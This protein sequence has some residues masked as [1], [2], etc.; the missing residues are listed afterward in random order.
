M[1]RK[2]SIHINGNLKTY[3]NLYYW[4]SVG[5]GTLPL[6]HLITQNIPRMWRKKSIHINGNLKTYGKEITP[7]FIACT[8]TGIREN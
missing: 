7:S 1:W 6:P 2:K 8:I 3:D 5:E 4:F